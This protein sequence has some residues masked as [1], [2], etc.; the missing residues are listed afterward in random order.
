MALFVR[1]SSRCMFEHVYML[2]ENYAQNTVFTVGE[3]LSNVFG[4]KQVNAN[5]SFR[6]YAMSGIIQST[7][8]SGISSQ[9][10]P[11]YNMYFDEFEIG[12]AHV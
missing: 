9:Q 12:R 5:E 1:G 7:Y 2:S 6:K 4:D 8:L 3:T 10:P 11:K